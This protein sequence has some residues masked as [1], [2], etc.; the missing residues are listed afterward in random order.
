MTALPAIMMAVWTLPR[1]DATT[2]VLPDEDGAGDSRGM[3]TTSV[4]PSCVTLNVSV[5]AM[6]YLLGGYPFGTVA[7]SVLRSAKVHCEKHATTFTVS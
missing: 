2:R 3:R 1:V 4:L 5:L 6:I 7:V